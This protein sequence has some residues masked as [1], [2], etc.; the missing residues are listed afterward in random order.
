MEMEPPAL[1]KGTR[2]ERL[3]TGAEERGNAV[4]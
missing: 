2:N 1:L 3:S 4:K